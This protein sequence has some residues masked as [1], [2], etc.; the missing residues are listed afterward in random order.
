MYEFHF[1]DYSYFYSFF[2]HWLH[3]TAMCIWDLQPDQ[4]NTSINIHIK[5]SF[6]V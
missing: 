5:E 4:S 2:M 1:F 6:S 3:H